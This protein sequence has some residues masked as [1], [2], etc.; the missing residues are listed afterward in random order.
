MRWRRALFGPCPIEG[1]GV[2]SRES[3]A[4][5][6][7]SDGSRKPLPGRRGSGF[8]AEVRSP[9]EPGGQLEFSTLA[10]DSGGQVLANLGHVIPPLIEAALEGIELLE[11]GIDPVNA[12]ESSPLQLNADRYARMARYFESIGPVGL[13]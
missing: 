1:E 8:R 12:I 9:F 5:G 10:A 2:S 11:A 13:G 4:T 3:C 6:R 7:P